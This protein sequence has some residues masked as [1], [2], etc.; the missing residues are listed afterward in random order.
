MVP[1]LWQ[2]L[3]VDAYER[4]KNI[5]IWIF[6]GKFKYALDLQ[7]AF[8]FFFNASLHALPLWNPSL[9]EVNGILLIVSF[10]RAGIWWAALCS[11]SPA[12]IR[13]LSWPC[14][15][16]LIAL[17]WASLLSISTYY[18]LVSSERDLKRGGHKGRAKISSV[19]LS[20]AFAGCL[21]HFAAYI[22][23][24]VLSYWMLYFCFVTGYLYSDAP[25][26]RCCKK[27]VGKNKPVFLG[28]RAVLQLSTRK[29]QTR[30]LLL[31]QYSSFFLE[32]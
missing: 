11:L 10:R 26:N 27:L 23:E 25:F 5:Y 30:R 12:E 4:I 9:G 20:G 2:G 7:N 19:A 3:T 8:F 21:L 18:L 14:P 16:T 28:N 32:R 29:G 17:V 22:K 15:K 1:R 6:K 31:N 13:T 24:M